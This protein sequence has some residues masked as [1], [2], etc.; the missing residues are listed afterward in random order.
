MPVAGFGSNLQ[1]RYVFLAGAAYGLLMRMVFGMPFFGSSELNSS[2]SQA[3][4]WS[5]V[6]LVPLLIGAL[7]V[8]FPGG[9]QRS[10]VY[11]LIAPWISILMFVGGTALLLIEGSICIAMALPLFLATGSVG[12]LAMWGVLRFYR[13]SPSTMAM[14]L[15]LPLLGGAWERNQPLPQVL[16]TADASLQVAAAPEEIWQLINHAYSIQPAEMRE[17]LAYRIGVPYPQSAQT[18]E[19]AQ[20]RVRK[21]RWDKGVRFDEPI[22][23]WEENRFVRWS[24]SFPPDA[25]PADALDEHVLIGGKY[26]DLVDTSYRLTPMGTGTR[27][28]IHVTY[29][30]STNFNWYANLWGRVLVDDAARTILRFYKRRAEAADQPASV[31]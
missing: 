26:F 3:M 6:C 30:I 9:R 27:M 19:T 7:T 16:H 18:V 29:R 31:S 11:A 1:K 17:G 28:D 2:A 25:I 4:L 23:D 10:L 12:G 15:V 14:L 24:Y 21:L 20:G 5:F 22:S 13:P 8:Y